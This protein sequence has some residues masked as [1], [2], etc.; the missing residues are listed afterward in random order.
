MK[1]KDHSQ[2]CKFFDPGQAEYR[3]VRATN[4][5]VPTIY[6][7][8]W[9]SSDFMFPVVRHSIVCGKIASQFSRCSNIAWQDSSFAG[10]EASSECLA[11]PLDPLLK[12]RRLEPWQGS[13]RSFHRRAKV[14]FVDIGGTWRD[15]V[16][17]F[18]QNQRAGTFP[19]WAVQLP[20]ACGEDSVADFTQA[21]TCSPQ[22]DFAMLSRNN[23]VMDF[24]KIGASLHL[25]QLGFASQLQ[26]FSGL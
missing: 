18:G 24:L 23:E 15:N 6:S 10:C 12:S 1:R 11:T 22:L 26:S 7:G 14:E 5:L 8:T 20:A 16:R 4:Q 2:F 3:D 25:K 13:H 19:A 9:S 17:S 21:L